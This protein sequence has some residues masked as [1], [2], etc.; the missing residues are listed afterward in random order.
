MINWWW[1]KIK[2]IIDWCALNLCSTSYVELIYVM[3]SSWMILQRNNNQTTKCA[4]WNK[5]D[6]KMFFSS[7]S[8]WWF[9]ARN[10]DCVKLQADSFYCCRHCERRTRVPQ[11]EIQIRCFFSIKQFDPNL[12]KTLNVFKNSTKRIKKSCLVEVSKGIRKA[13]ELIIKIRKICGWSH[14]W[15]SIFHQS[16]KINA[17]YRLWPVSP[18]TS[19]FALA[20]AQSRQQCR[21]H[22]HI[23]S[24]TWQIVKLNL[25]DA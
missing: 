18:R 20:I 11:S 24:K 13:P 5:F 3:C 17:P 10:F 2:S 4:N 1:I 21:A 25:R 7:R 6:N 8:K 12:N 16:N 19:C 22:F 9:S 23:D 14:H 15:F